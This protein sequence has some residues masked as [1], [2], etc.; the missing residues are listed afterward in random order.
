M[1]KLGINARPPIACNFF[2]TFTLQIDLT[3]DINIHGVRIVRENTRI[4]SESVKTI[5]SIFVISIT[6]L[7]SPPLRSSALA[8]CREHALPPTV[9]LRRFF[10]L[11]AVSEIRTTSEGYLESLKFLK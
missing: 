1:I 2:R 6:V 3:I 5:V 4:R 10:Q 11:V 9:L 8:S 7:L